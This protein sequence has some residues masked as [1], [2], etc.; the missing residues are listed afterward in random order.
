MT[1]RSKDSDCF[2]WW[3]GELLQEGDFHALRVKPKENFCDQNFGSE[4]S[5]AQGCKAEEAEGAREDRSKKM[6]HGRGLCRVSQPGW[7]QAS[8]SDVIRIFQGL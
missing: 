7:R 5:T 2:Q 3:S 8:C 4:I 1:L 6:G